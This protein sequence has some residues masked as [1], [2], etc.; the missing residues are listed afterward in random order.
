M[1]MFRFMFRFRFRFRFVKL[2]MTYTAMI[3]NAAV[4]ALSFLSR[5]LHHFIPEMLDAWE[6]LDI[7]GMSNT[8]N[9]NSLSRIKDNLLSHSLIKELVGLGGLRQGH[10]AIS[11][12]P[13]RVHRG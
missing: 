8:E 6:L 3:Q 2:L 12:E 13:R 11:Q 4:P 9:S 5:V 7:N 10:H 1:F